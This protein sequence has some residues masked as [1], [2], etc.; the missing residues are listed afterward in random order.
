MAEYA[1]KVAPECAGKRLDLLLIEFAES[2]ELGLSR[3]FLQK[4]ILDKKVYEA[5]GCALKP[6]YK[7]KQGQEFKIVLEEK[8]DHIPQAEDIPLEIIHEDADLVVINKPAGLVVHPA[9]GNYA[10]TLVNALLY[11]FRELSDIN[12]DRPGIVHRLDKETSGVLV[13]AKNNFSHLALARQFSE[14]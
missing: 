14:H 12:K 10:H 5:S 7:V 8:K 4:L 9:A 2:N 13:V 6:N 11:R 1:L 3:T